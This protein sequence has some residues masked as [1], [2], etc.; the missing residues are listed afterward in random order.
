MSPAFII[1]CSM[2]MAWFFFD[3]ATPATQRIQDRLATE[4]ALVPSL[5]L[6]EVTNVLAMAEKRNRTTSSDSTQFL[7]QLQKCDIQTDDSWQRRTFDHILPLCRKHSLTTYDAAYL[8]LAF[9]SQLPL[10]SLDIDLKKAAKT[11]GIPLL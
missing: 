7:E 3:E 5:W 4:A 11:L 6:L 9:R 10:A 8:D 1:D 2:T